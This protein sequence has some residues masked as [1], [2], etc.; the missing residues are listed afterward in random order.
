VPY[1]HG[2][3]ALITAS[4]SADGPCGSTPGMP[5][6]H[7]QEARPLERH[8]QRSST[9][10]QCLAPLLPSS[11]TPIQQPILRNA[12]GGAG[13]SCAYLSTGRPAAAAATHK[14]P[15]EAPPMDE[16]G[17]TARGF[18]T[19]QFPASLFS[20]LDSLLQQKDRHA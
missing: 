15:T 3:P 16:Q 5:S 18:S 11:A 10:G 7:V 1:M 14:D 8:R 20:R 13:V 4:P 17:H 19:L 12:Q 2:S 9:P 6:E